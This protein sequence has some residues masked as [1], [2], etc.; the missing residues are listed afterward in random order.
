MEGDVEDILWRIASQ[1]AR[2]VIIQKIWETE[3][4]KIYELFKDK[5]WEVLNMRVL[6]TESGKV[7]F[8]FNGNQVVVPKSEQVTRDNYSQDVKM[9]VYVSDVSNDEKFWPKV[10]LSRKN[11]W[12]VPAIF[13]MYVPELT[14][15]TVVIEKVERYAWV[16]TKLLVSSCFEE[17]DPAWTM[18]WP[19]WIRV[20]S[21]MEELSGEKIDI[22][23]NN[24]NIEEMITKALTPANILKV[25][26]NE[27]SKEAKAYI[28]P[29]ERAKAIWKNWI[30]INLA[31]KL[32]WYNISLVEVSE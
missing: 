22:V 29:S 20:K 32:I 19:K 23:T 24:W 10:T 30:N 21:V 27:E 8:D 17:I 1:A 15:W 9:Y 3:K 11:K 14:D 25:E 31:T 28:L 16:K 4:Q 6:M 26:V 18:I 5:A 7:V 13:S 12:I 2:Q